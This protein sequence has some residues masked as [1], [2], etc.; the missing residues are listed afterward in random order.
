MLCGKDGGLPL[1]HTMTHQRWRP[2]LRSTPASHLHWWQWK[3][4]SRPLSRES[5]ERLGIMQD[6]TPVK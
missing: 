1:L 3:L 2:A 5:Q 6:T 4:V